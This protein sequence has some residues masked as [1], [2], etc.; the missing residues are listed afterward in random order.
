MTTKTRLLS[1]RRKSHLWPFRPR[2]ARTGFQPTSQIPWRL[3]GYSLGSARL[4]PRPWGLWHGSRLGKHKKSR[5]NSAPSPCAASS[6]FFNGLLSLL[7]AVGLLATA[8][9]AT[10]AKAAKEEVVVYCSVDQVFGEPILRQFERK[11]GIKVRP[12]FDVE[13][14]KTV[15]LVN[16]LIAE[17][18]RP[19][20]DVFWNSEVSRSIV[21]AEKNIF[22]PYSSPQSADIPALFKDPKHRW[23]GFGAR[24]RIILYNTNLVS[25]E[26]APRSILDLT[27]PKWR[28]KVAIAYPL[29]GTTAM[30]MAALHLRW[31]T[32]RFTTYLKK[33]LANEVQVVDGNA[34]ARDLV[35]A[36]KAAVCLTDTDDANV[37]L[38]RGAPVRVIFPDQAGMGTLMI[39]NTVGL[40]N[41]APHPAAAKR[42]ID[43]LLSR[44]VEQRLANGESAQIPVRKGLAPP[45]RF[46][47]LDN[48]KAMNVDY[49]A[50]AAK[51]EATA[52]ICQ[53][54][55]VR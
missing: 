38:E 29:F 34:V 25:A 3:F 16:R 30:H 54:L 22:A 50:V 11:T 36:G 27:K 35:V 6:P 42:L 13:A 19:R 5:H 37:A 7:L 15:G 4:G 31:G 52:R 14:T 49:G 51:L 39:P 43:Y 12:L 9:L 53:R 2:S 8:P 32:Q 1:A 17:R 20:A 47:Q 24:A 45:P 23:A 55:F 18:R 28:G 33:L 21:L 46:P 26:E 48:I 40:I 41:G 10:S 44:E